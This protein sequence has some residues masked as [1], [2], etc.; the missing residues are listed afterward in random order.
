VQRKRE[1]SSS[2]KDARMMS[3]QK[4]MERLRNDKYQT[5]AKRV[6]ATANEPT[7]LTKN[8]QWCYVVQEVVVLQPKS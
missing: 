8:S 2:T 7:R 3:F 5:G 6:K 1:K 4:D